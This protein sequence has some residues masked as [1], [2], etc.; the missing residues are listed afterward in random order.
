MNSLF[1]R[2]VLAVIVWG[3]S[4][5]LIIAYVKISFRLWQ[6]AIHKDL[7]LALKPFLPL[8]AGSMI[9]WAIILGITG[10]VILS[11]RST[12]LLSSGLIIAGI[13]GTLT[14]VNIFIRQRSMQK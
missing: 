3:I 13:V 1:F 10:L 4:L 11:P 12:G 7:N 9:G 14:G 8:L 2:Y 5:F 6:G